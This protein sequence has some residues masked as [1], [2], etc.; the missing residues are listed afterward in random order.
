LTKGKG[1][2]EACEDDFSKLMQTD[3][4]LTL[5]RLVAGVAH[6]IGNPMTGILTYAYLL[7]DSLKEDDPRREDVDVI[8]NE[9]IRCR[10]IVRGLL[11]FARQCKLKREQVDMN[12]LIRDTLKLVQKQEEFKKIELVFELDPEV[13]L[14]DADPY[15]IKQVILNLVINACEATQDHGKVWVYTRSSKDNWVEMNVE[16]HGKGIPGEHLEAIFEP[17]FTTKKN[18]GGTGLGLSISYGIIKNHGG[19]IRVKSSPGKGSKFKVIL[20]RKPPE[21]NDNKN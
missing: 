11:D 6:E 8:I 21:G 4:L 19:D 5:G 3:R 15:Q 18:Q 13:G 14:I 2:Q 12:Q 9:T 16:D 17:F 20:P 1:S 7:R 10:E